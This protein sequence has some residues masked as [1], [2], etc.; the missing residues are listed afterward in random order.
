MVNIITEECIRGY[1]SPEKGHV[2]EA[3]LGGQGRLLGGGSL[4]LNLDAE[5]GRKRLC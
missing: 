1:R 5:A 4:P 2:N 3:G